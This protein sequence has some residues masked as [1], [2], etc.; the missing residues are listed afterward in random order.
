[1]ESCSS[2]SVLVA[3]LVIA[4]VANNEKQSPPQL[5]DY[6]IAT[7][8]VGKGTTASLRNAY[9]SCIFK[10]FLRSQQEGSPSHE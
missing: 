10:C 1:M 7:Q 8:Y 3:V 4:S 6:E 2:S 5:V 9:F